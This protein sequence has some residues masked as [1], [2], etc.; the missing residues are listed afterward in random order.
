MVDKVPSVLLPYPPGYI[1]LS[2]GKFYKHLNL[3]TFDGQ[4]S[5]AARSQLVSPKGFYLFS[6]KV[7]RNDY[8]SK[9]CLVQILSLVLDSVTR[10]RDRI[11]S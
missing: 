4:L 6:R 9:Y 10:L 5:G 2:L 1:S 7:I 3:S 8:K 11:R